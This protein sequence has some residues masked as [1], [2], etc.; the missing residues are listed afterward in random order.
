MAVAVALPM[1]VPVAVSVSVAVAVAVAGDLFWAM[2][3]AAIATWRAVLVT[4]NPL[5][6]FLGGC[7]LYYLCR[8]AFYSETATP[9]VSG[10]FI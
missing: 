8:A 7:A 6:W 3:T 5:T 4:M 9:P 2:A 10:S 1:A